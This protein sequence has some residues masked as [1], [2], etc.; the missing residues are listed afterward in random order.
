LFQVKLPAFTNRNKGYNPPLGGREKRNGKTMGAKVPPRAVNCVG[1]TLDRS[2]AE[3][4][5]D[6]RVERN[7]GTISQ[8]QG[9]SGVK[10]SQPLYRFSLKRQER[11]NVENPQEGETPFLRLLSAATGSFWER[12]KNLHWVHGEESIQPN[13]SMMAAQKRSGPAVRRKWK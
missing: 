7:G 8:R 2:F 11:L 1:A 9:K 13:R 6:G 3:E 10:T 12:R 4:S 5:A